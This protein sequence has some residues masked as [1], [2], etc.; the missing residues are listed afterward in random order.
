MG[1][2]GK[3]YRDIRKA[4]VPKIYSLY[5]FT[6]FVYGGKTHYAFIDDDF[7][8]KVVDSKGSILWKSMTQF[9]SDVSFRIKPMPGSAPAGTSG[10]GDEWAVVN[11][12]IVSRGSEVLIN[13]NISSAAGIF[14]RG[15]SYSGG[16]VQSLV[17]NGAMFLENWRSQVIPGYLADIQ[18]QAIDSQKGDQL[19]VAVNLPSGSILSADSQSALMI[20][21]AQ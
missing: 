19:L 9:G 11:V 6:P 20:A 18:L 10:E 15:G 2:N 5:G 7:R 13:H 16:A 12:R 17:W 21:R 4:P 1:W 8:I 14:K 3:T